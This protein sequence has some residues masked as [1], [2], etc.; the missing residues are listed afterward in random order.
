RRDPLLHAR[1]LWN[2]LRLTHD[3]VAL[4][5][6]VAENDFVYFVHSFAATHCKD[7]EI[8]ATTQYGG[9][10]VALIGRGNIYGTQFHPEKSQ[11]VGL[12]IIRNF[13]GL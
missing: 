7:E 10:V 9:D 5:S 2:K 11:A 4:L 12:R 1:I 13:L 8:L 6:G 3:G